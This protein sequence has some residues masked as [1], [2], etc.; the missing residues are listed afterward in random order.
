[1][2]QKAVATANRRNELAVAKV[3]VALVAARVVVVVV[4]VRA[5]VEAGCRAEEKVHKREVQQDHT[6]TTTSTWRSLRGDSMSCKCRPKPRR[7]GWGGG[8]NEGG[9]QGGERWTVE[10]VRRLAPAGGGQTQAAVR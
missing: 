5:A 1:V 7:E 9:V 10:Q 6:S 3:G 2:K 8:S 4:V